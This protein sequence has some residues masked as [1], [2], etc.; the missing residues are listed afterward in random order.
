MEDNRAAGLA[1]PRNEELQY[2]LNINETAY[3]DG[4]F[5]HT[6]PDNRKPNP[7]RSAWLTVSKVIG[8]AITLKVKEGDNIKMTAYGKYYSIPSYSQILPSTYFAA[9]GGVFAGQYGGESSQQLESA[10]SIGFSQLG[11]WG[12]YDVI[13]PQ[14]TGQKIN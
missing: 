2:F 1:S 8:P 9:L 5:N 12:E 14:K 4:I 11:M 3:S 13:T 7:R 10:F 6:S